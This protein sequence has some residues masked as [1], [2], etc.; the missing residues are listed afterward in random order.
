MN[1][2][3]SAGNS[4]SILHAATWAKRGA[5]LVLISGVANVSVWPSEASILST[6]KTRLSKRE[7]QCLLLAAQGKS[8]WAIAEML[9]LSDRT[10]HHAIERAK[11]KYGVVTRVQAVVYAIAEGEFSAEDV[12]GSK[13]D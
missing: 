13:Q 7:R 5:I 6:P 3:A 12:L 8:D 2:Q 11:N 1:I 4:K 10:V 9:D